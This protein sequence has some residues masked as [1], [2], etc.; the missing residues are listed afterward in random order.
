M[1]GLI[2]SSFAL[3]D[4]KKGRKALLRRIKNGETKIPVT[5]HGYI[6]KDWSGDD[7]TSIEFEID[8]R[9]VVEFNPLPDV[10]DAT[11]KLI[12][13]AEQLL[14]WVDEFMKHGKAPTY[15]QPGAVRGLI[16]KVKGEA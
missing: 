3:L 9:A 7:G 12:H 8:V 10:S 13:E 14:E 6:V 2:D 11:R 16:A 1:S 15:D 4:V 5:I